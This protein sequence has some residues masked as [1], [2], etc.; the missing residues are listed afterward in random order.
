MGINNVYL[1]YRGSDGALR[2]L[3]IFRGYSVE[4]SEIAKRKRRFLSYGL[5]RT[6][7]DLCLK[8]CLRR[9]TPAMQTDAVSAATGVPRGVQLTC[10]F[11]QVPPLLK[12]DLPRTPPK[13]E[14]CLSGALFASF[15]TA[16]DGCWRR[17]GTCGFWRYVVT[18][19]LGRAYCPHLQA[20]YSPRSL[21]V[22]LP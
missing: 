13:R 11:E 7:F 2:G 20:I 14:C 15:F 3:R 16:G 6:L 18:R 22:A 4:I 17:G 19:H 8:R 1:A 21:R 10:K 9:L 12:F 5:H